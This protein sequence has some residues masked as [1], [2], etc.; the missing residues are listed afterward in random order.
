VL[1]VRAQVGKLGAAPIIVAPERV[2]ATSG[3]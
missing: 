3:S 1:L 2:P